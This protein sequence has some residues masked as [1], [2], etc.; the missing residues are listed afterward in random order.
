MAAQLAERGRN[1]M[2]SAK[3]RRWRLRFL[4]L[5]LGRTSS[6]T[7]FRG[8]RWDGREFGD[9]RCWA[10]GRSLRW[11]VDFLVQLSI[12]NTNR[13]AL[14]NRPILPLIP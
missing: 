10:A 6:G 5:S 13:T 9:Q 8:R 11:L 1:F 3:M 4:L 12:L 14:E 7:R 2:E